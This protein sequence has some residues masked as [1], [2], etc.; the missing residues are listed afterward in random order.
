MIA[1]RLFATLLV[2]SLAGCGSSNSATTA[3]DATATPEVDSATATPFESSHHSR[4][5]RRH[6]HAGYSATAPIANPAAN[7]RTAAAAGSGS[8]PCD[9]A[10]FVTI[11]SQLA[12]GALEGDQEVDVCGPVTR[13]L[14]SR[15]TR[16]GLHG[17][18]YIQVAPGDT[19]EIVSD[20]GEMNA[21]AWPWVKVGDSSTVRGRYYYD[22]ASS[23][24]IDWTHHGTSHSW[25]SPGYVVINGTQY[26]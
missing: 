3:S 20:L 7:A 16:S 23:Q 19:I 22:S 1:R 14:E 8:Y 12:S 17:Y 21:P 6:H 4:H 10:K 25:P 18:Y 15:T 24:G 5:H 13:V 2:A 26:Q 11:Q 9:D